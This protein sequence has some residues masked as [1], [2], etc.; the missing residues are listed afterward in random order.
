M[1]LNGMMR[2]HIQVSTMIGTHMHAW[3]EGERDLRAVLHENLG[4]VLHSK[5]SARQV[6]AS[7]CQI[8]HP[9]PERTRQFYPAACF[10]A[11]TCSGV[12][13]L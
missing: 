8:N 10:S 2:G 9:T 5:K 11:R 7:A 12:Q 4:S 13:H 6:L 3:G 1:I